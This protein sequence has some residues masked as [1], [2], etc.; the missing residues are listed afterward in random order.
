MDIVRYRIGLQ[1]VVNSRFDLNNTTKAGLDRFEYTGYTGF[2]L[3]AVA[4]SNDEDIIRY[5]M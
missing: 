3:A 1:I 5:F 4:C 2:I